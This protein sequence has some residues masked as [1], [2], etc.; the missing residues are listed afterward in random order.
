MIDWKL[1]T[2]TGVQGS[3]VNKTGKNVS[4]KR[5]GGDQ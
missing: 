2:G 5:V 4:L 1:A 3:K